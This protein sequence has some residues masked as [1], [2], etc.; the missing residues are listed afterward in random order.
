MIEDTFGSIRS[1]FRAWQVKFVPRF[2]RLIACRVNLLE[3][4]SVDLSGVSPNQRIVCFGFIGIHLFDRLT[5]FHAFT[6]ASV[7]TLI[8]IGFFPRGEPSIMQP[9]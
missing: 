4:I 1:V 5:C 9:V 7:A 3:R 6:P 8:F 2:D